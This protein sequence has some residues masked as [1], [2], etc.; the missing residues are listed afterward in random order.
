MDVALRVLSITD[1]V[2]LPVMLVVAV[3]AAAAVLGEEGSGQLSP[4]SAL[5]KDRTTPDDTSA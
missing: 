1:L 3:A 2:V 4:E 5:H